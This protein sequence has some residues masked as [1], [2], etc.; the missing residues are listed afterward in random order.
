[1][2]VQ[3]QFVLHDYSFIQPLNVFVIHKNKS[4]MLPSKHFW[5]RKIQAMSRKLKD[6][7]V[8]NIR[9]EFPLVCN[10]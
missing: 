6:L 1:M 7:Q 3:S 2:V 10:N 4:K 5:H 9:A 8:C